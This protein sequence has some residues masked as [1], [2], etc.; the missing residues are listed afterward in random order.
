MPRI[1]ALSAFAPT[2]LTP[3]HGIAH[4]AVQLL[5][6]AARANLEAEPDD[7]HSNLGWEGE[8]RRFLTHPLSDGGQAQIGLSLAPL[9]LTVLSRGLE[10]AS[11]D[12]AGLAYSDA[13]NWLDVRLGELGLKPASTVNLPYDLPSEAESIEVFPTDRHGE[14]LQT[15]SAWFDLAQRLISS[16]AA[17][18]A[19]L[20]PG[21]SPVRC[22]P[23]HFDLASYVQLEEGDFETAKGIGVGMSPGDETYGQPYFY[24]NPW[25]R[26]DLAE[27][28]DLPAPGHW[29][30]EGFVGA[31]ATGEDVLTLQ[32]VERGLSAFID[33]A[34]DLGRMKL[35]A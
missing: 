19:D 4:R 20:K 18:R 7:S 8:G 24:I 34:F 2:A 25:P 32:E 35:G 13:G 5:T 1:E 22:W 14:E 21:P 23:H 33:T 3:A 12:L 6:S 30:R 17:A 26:L 11:R 29:H 15:L 9:R 27:L 28:P 16:F 10:I 31:I